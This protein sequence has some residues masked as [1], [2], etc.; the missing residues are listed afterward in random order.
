MRVAIILYRLG[1][2][3]GHTTSSVVYLHSQERRR[4][5]HARTRSERASKKGLTKE[6]IPCQMK[7]KRPQSP[8][9]SA[10][11]AELSSAYQISPIIFLSFRSEKLLRMGRLGWTSSSHRLHRHCTVAQGTLNKR[12][13]LHTEV[14]WTNS[15]CFFFNPMAHQHNAMHYNIIWGI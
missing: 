10:P 14:I 8:A 3:A 7:R 11:K 13:E 4:I 1:G 9:A 5:V 12:R 6:M 2:C 15:L